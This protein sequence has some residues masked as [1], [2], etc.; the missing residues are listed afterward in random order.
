MTVSGVVSLADSL[1]PGQGAQRFSQ[2]FGLAYRFTVSIANQDFGMWQS[3]SG[4]KVE[5]KPTE[6]KTGGHYHGARY[7]PGE[8]VY[9]KVVLKRAVEAKESEKLQKWLVAT[10]KAWLRDE[11]T[12]GSLAKVSLFNSYGDVVMSWSL[13]NA[14]PSAWSGPD[15]DAGASK[16]AIETL[17]LVHEGFVVEPGGK[18]TA[19]SG[20][21]SQPGKLTLG[22]GTTTVTFVYPPTEIGLAKATPGSYRNNAKTTDHRPTTA[23]GAPVRLS[24]RD[25]NRTIYSLNNLV[26]EGV[27]TQAIVD[28]LTG[29][30]TGP[31]TRATGQQRD[32]QTLHPLKL[33]WGDGF[34]DLEVVLTSLTA[35]YTRFTA[36]GVPARAKVTLKLEELKAHPPRA[37]VPEKPAP[38]G[39]SNPTS[40]G[41]PGRRSHLLLASENLPTLARQS[42][43]RQ[44]RWR[45]VAEANGVDDPFR[46]LP[47]TTIYLP[48]A[49]EIEPAGKGGGP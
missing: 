31:Q 15:L 47:G 23:G 38:T 17:E 29:W 18:D 13:A 25:G 28:Q 40:G 42:Y 45:D 33:T 12:Q 37:M 20:K 1:G 19:A 44:D 11:R 49:S 24:A 8:L 9:P 48:A 32:S 36:R 3:C 21:D 30:A 46:I 34:S 22:D 7:L 39:A 5:F 41:I 14:R 26:V 4:L 35:S 6:I 16:V 43:G 27:N 10:A 2:A